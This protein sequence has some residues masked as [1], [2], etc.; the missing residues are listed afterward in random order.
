LHPLTA[1]AVASLLLLAAMAVG[2]AAATPIYVE[3]AKE[4]VN[5]RER[6]GTR[7]PK[8]GS[9]RRGEVFRVLARQGDWY[10]VE[11]PEGGSAWIFR[12]LIQRV[13]IHLESGH[14]VTPRGSHANLRAQARKGAPLAG[15]LQEGEVLSVLRQDGDWYEVD[16]GGE[17]RAWV[18]R[19]VVRLL[20]P[21]PAKELLN[22]LRTTFAGIVR[23]GAV[24]EVT[25]K[26]YHEAVLDMVVE[27]SWHFLTEAQRRDLLAR[28]AAGFE[29]LL[30]E[31]ERF[32]GRY[33][34]L[35]LVVI[36][37]PSNTVV[38]TATRKEVRL[39]P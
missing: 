33:Y 29:A 36:T 31:T 10:E 6:P 1:T 19:G 3:V 39:L 23:W 34:N 17:A 25:L 9:A 24:N 21:D 4:E 7:Y 18:F 22:D 28:A 16:L 11:R 5:L 8:V 27:S 20:E 12:R 13:A 38:G 14:R 15:R 32:R 2:A 30:K 26:R 37:D 35:P